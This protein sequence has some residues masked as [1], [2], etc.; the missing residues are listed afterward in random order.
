VIEAHVTFRTSNWRGFESVAKIV[1]V[2]LSTAKTLAYYA[3]KHLAAI[4]P[5][6]RSDRAALSGE[7]IVQTMLP[8]ATVSDD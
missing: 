5:Q 2:A 4:L 1:G 6:G 8:F 3:G 7:C